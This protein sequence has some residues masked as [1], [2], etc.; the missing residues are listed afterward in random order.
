MFDLT[1]TFFDVGLGKGLIIEKREGADKRD[2]KGRDEFHSS[3]ING[4]RTEKAKVD[5]GPLF[6]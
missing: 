1:I 4:F 3:Q 2:K 6:V 5:Q